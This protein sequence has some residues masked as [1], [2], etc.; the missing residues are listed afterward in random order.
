MHI[1]RNECGGKP[2]A[3]LSDGGAA[4]RSSCPTHQ[5]N[6]RSETG[7]GHSASRARRSSLQACGPPRP[8][9]QRDRRRCRRHGQLSLFDLVGPTQAPVPLPAAAWLLLMGLLGAAAGQRRRAGQPRHACGVEFSRRFRSG[10]GEVSLHS[11]LGVVYTSV[12]GAAPLAPHRPPRMASSIREPASARLAPAPH[13]DRLHER[14]RLLSRNART[15][16][17][18]NVTVAPGM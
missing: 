17:R 8:G 13:P 7:A 15:A 9:S 3:R 11:T 1:G 12:T 18:C 16:E 10:R 5:P 4:R 2:S 14:E 6:L